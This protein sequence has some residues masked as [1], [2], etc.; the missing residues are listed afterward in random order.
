MNVFS[1]SNPLNDD[2]FW[3]AVIQLHH[4]FEAAK[5]KNFHENFWKTPDDEYKTNEDK[6]TVAYFSAKHQLYEER[7]KAQ[8]TAKVFS[9]GTDPVAFAVREL[10]Q[11]LARYED[12]ILEDN[13][14]MHDEIAE[15]MRNVTETVRVYTS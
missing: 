13:Q 11:I 9:N 2:D 1:V 14:Q 12:E 8:F 5:T 7:S 3:T 10:V 6:I 4:D 15:N